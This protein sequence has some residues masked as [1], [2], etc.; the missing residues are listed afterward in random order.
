MMVKTRNYRTWTH[1]FLWNNLSFFCCSVGFSPRM[2]HS[3]IW[4]RVK[5]LC[6][7]I[8][9]IIVFVSFKLTYQKYY[10][11]LVGCIGVV[12]SAVL[13]QI[14]LTFTRI[15][16][17]C[18]TVYVRF[19]LVYFRYFLLLFFSFFFLIL[20]GTIC[21][22]TNGTVFS[23]F[24]GLSFIKWSVQCSTF[25]KI[26]IELPTENWFWNPVEIFFSFTNIDIFC[27]KF[28]EESTKNG[29]RTK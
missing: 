22:T 19:I 5:V 26:K 18:H 11:C 12:I 9:F 25:S 1:T 16:H 28:I 2:I 23:L 20:S 21:L 29:I 3:T 10:W 17:G 6:V 7:S 13:T 8:W 24:D 14:P 15:I 27:I 4:F